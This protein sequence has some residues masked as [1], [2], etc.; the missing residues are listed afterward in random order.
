LSIQHNITHISPSESSNLTLVHPIPS[1]QHPVLVY[2]ASLPSDNSRKNMTR[3]L[4]M[5]AGILGQLDA[6]SVNWGA[7]KYQHVAAIRST[8][9]ETYSPATVNVMLSALRGVLKETWRLGYIS[10][11][12]YQRAVDIKNVKGETIPS[13]R[14][15]KAGE[16]LALSHACYD[17]ESAAGVRDSAIIGILYTTGLRRSELV[18]LQLSDFDADTGKLTIQRGKGRKSRTVYVSNGALDALLDWIIIRGESPG[19]LFHPINKGGRIIHKSMTSQ[20]VYNMLKKRAAEAGVSDFS[21]HDFRRTFVG[22]MLDR[23]V[24]IVTVQKIAGH[25]NPSTTSRYDRRPEETKRQA[26]GKLHYPYKRR[27]RLPLDVD[28]GES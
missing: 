20:A 23:G 22:D 17:D 5:I 10:A 6:I 15:L 16:F 25:A 11:E 7:V 8:L 9:M 19:A 12:D 3:H 27:K 21:P 4:N 14:D 26:A 18:E 13:G 2:I 1:D 24:D 28:G